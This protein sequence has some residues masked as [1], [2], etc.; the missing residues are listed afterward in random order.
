MAWLRSPKQLVKSIVIFI[1]ICTS[2][3]VFLPNLHTTTTQVTTSSND[4]SDDNVTIDLDEIKVKEF[5]TTW[6]EGKLNTNYSIL[7]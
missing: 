2:L 1:A 7:N 5:N 4:N 3:F 6:D